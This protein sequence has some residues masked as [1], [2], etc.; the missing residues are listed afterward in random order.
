MTELHE[1]HKWKRNT[2][3]GDKSFQMSSPFFGSIGAFHCL[4]SRTCTSN[5][6]RW[7]QGSCLKTAPSFLHARTIRAA[8]E[9]INEDQY[10]PDRRADFFGISTLSMVRFEPQL[11][12]LATIPHHT[13]P[14]HT[15]PLHTTP[16]KHTPARPNARTHPHTHT[17]T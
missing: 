10:L 1:R 12:F 2:I 17:H 16:R 13:T 6:I 9:R 7:P 15:T 11:S 8:N 4:T 5:V 14:L 3:D